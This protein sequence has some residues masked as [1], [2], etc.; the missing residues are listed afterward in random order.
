MLWLTPLRSSLLLLLAAAAGESRDT[1]IFPGP[2]ERYIQ[3]PE[4][5]HVRP[6]KVYYTEGTVSAAADS[7]GVTVLKG[8]GALVTYEFAQNIA[9]RYHSSL[10]RP[11]SPFLSIFK[12]S[13]RC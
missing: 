13:N 11:P 9:G 3:A 8:Q 7:S 6:Q 4:S 5:R 10:K 2:W 1:P 12:W